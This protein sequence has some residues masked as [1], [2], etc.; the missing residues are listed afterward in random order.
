MLRSNLAVD[1]RFEGREGK[2]TYVHRRLWPALM[3]L[4][5]RFKKAQL[6]RTSDSDWERSVAN[7]GRALTRAERPP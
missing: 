3:G 6:A 4:A 1:R 2:V 5:S 7:I